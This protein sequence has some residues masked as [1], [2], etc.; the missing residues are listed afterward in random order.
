MTK[1]E[2]FVI[3]CLEGKATDASALFDSLMRDAIAEKLE[4]RKQQVAENLIEE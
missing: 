2:E 3:N 4:E 1:T